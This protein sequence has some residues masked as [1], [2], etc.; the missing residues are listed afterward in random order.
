MR[1][2]SWIK[3]TTAVS[4]EFEG[5]WPESSVSADLLWSERRGVL[6]AWSEEEEEALLFFFMRFSFR[7]I[8][9][10]YGF[11]NESLTR[12]DGHRC[13]SSPTFLPFFLKLKKKIYWKR[14]ESG[15]LKILENVWNER[16][17]SQVWDWET[18]NEH[19]LVSTI[20][21]SGG[22]FFP[23]VTLFKYFII[24]IYLRKI[25]LQLSSHSFSPCLLYF[26]SPIS[27][28][29]TSNLTFF[30]LLAPFR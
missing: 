17:T 8:Q 5:S 26:I 13:I 19:T 14:E 29:S 4:F 9:V 10:R 24:F 28:P 2:R 12:C 30:F 27:S 18:L 11:L 25:I 16:K 22:I 1:T 21:E 20:W 6:L 7:F 3:A 15:E 23:L